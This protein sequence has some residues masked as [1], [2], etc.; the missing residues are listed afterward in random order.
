M[1]ARTAGLRVKLPAPSGPYRIGTMSLRLVDRSRPDPW[2]AS[3]PYREL[4][5]SVWYPA[6]STGRHRLAAHMQPGE[7]ERFDAVVGPGLEIP[8]GTVAWAAT[9]THALQGAPADTRAGRRPVV[10]YSP[11]AGDPRTWGTVLVEELASRGC[12]VMTI[13]HTYESPGVQFP[14]GSVKDNDQLIKEFRK[15]MHDGTVPRLLAKVLRTRVADT[16]FVLSRLATLPRGLAKAIDPHRIG[17]VGHSGGGFT[18]AQTIYQDRRI[19]A[20]IDLDGTLEFN[21]EPIGT[22]LSPVAAHGL[23]RPFLLMGRQGIDHTNEPSWRSF[24]SHSSG[25]RRD[26]TLRGSK[27]Q[28]YTDAEAIVPQAGLPQD[29]LEGVIGTV[30][31][32][33]AL[34]AEHAYVTSF[35]ERWLRRRDDHLLD[36]PSPR[37]PEVTFVR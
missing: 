8:R 13:D 31:P 4:M 2:V 29:V 32:A 28:S 27:H 35:F 10:V 17:M 19:K 15:A 7:A 26:L 30:D 21:S 25:W 34:A 23:R 12:V 20:G 16:R 14:D 9:R 3:P 33:R 6:L 18:A 36:G 11:G 24:W 5:I 22:N 37:Y 1:Q